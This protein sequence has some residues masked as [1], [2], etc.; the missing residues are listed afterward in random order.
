MGELLSVILHDYHQCHGIFVLPLAALVLAWGKGRGLRFGVGSRFV[1]HMAIGL[2]G[3]VLATY[4]AILIQ[5]Q[6]SVM[7]GD[8]LEGLVASISWLVVHGRPGYPDWHDGDLY[9]GI[10]GPLLFWINGVARLISPTIIVTKL[11][12]AGALVL[13]LL[14][15]WDL[16]SRAIPGWPVRLLLVALLVEQLLPYR[17]T[18]F[19]IRSE[20]FL[21]LLA[22]L[23]ILAGVR[24]RPVVA[25]LPVGLLAGLAVDLK[26]HAMFY[27]LPVGLLVLA[28]ASDGRQMAIFVTGA[29]LAAMVAF[30]VPIL[31][32]PST[33]LLYTHYLALAARHGFSASAVVENLEIAAALATPSLICFLWRRPMLAKDDVW[34]LA[35][36]AV[37]TL[38]VIIL[39]SKNGALPNYL[40]PL[41][42]SFFYLTVRTLAALP[43]HADRPGTKHGRAATAFLVVFAC[44]AGSWL[45]MI[46][47]VP[48]LASYNTVMTGKRA[49]FLALLTAHPDAETGIGDDASYEDTYFAL[50]QVMRNGVLHIAVPAW[51]DLREGGISESYALRF[52]DRCVVPAWILPAGAPFSLITPYTNQPLF[53]GAFRA[54]FAQNYRLAEHGHSYDV[55]VCQKGER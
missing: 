7:Y 39:G 37:A 43:R 52:V 11:V 13:G 53:S 4:F 33:V 16:S 10:Y 54:A 27:M 40:L 46:Q 19:W 29:A 44:N 48:K 18:A 22:A 21:Y 51:M 49:E 3:L 24:L 50:V 26:I 34:F 25:I 20:P 32:D 31:A 1:S 15:L 17:F 41:A 30:V 35:G 9:G 5:R 14:G 38:I 55:W 45:L 47:T 28:R 23:A 42:P 2:A 12:A 6:S 36:L 8:H